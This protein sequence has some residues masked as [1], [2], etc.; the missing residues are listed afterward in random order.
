MCK[1]A[2]RAMVLPAD[3]WIISPHPSSS[4]HS[5][6]RANMTSLENEY[7]C[8]SMT[9]W[10]HCERLGPLEGCV[11]G[12]HAFDRMDFLAIDGGSPS[13]ITRRP[14]I[15]LYLL[16]VAGIWTSI[17]DMHDYDS[18]KSLR[19][20]GGAQTSLPAHPAT[21]CVWLCS[22]GRIPSAESQGGCVVWTFF[23]PSSLAC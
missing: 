11:D 13:R 16:V 12:P 20:C 18:P 4:S 22:L 1:V 2:L 8:S 5:H 3:D 21:A 15:P 9:V 23:V 17:V 6:G 7:R 14:S 19:G 10:P